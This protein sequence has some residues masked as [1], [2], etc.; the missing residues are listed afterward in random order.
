[1]RFLVAIE[2]PPEEADI[3]GYIFCRYLSNCIF[4]LRQTRILERARRN[5]FCREVET[6][7]QATRSQKFGTVVEIGHCEVNVAT[8]VFYVGI[9]YKH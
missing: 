3:A 1:M 7:V 9:C 6:P 8:V 2:L 5:S 4:N